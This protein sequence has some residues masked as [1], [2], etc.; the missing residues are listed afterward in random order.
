M[1]HIIELLECEHQCILRNSHGDCTHDCEN[2]DLVRDDY[3][4]H[5]MYM[6]AITILKAQEP[7]APKCG[8]NVGVGWWYACGACNGEIVRSDD[9]C[10][11]CG[12][13]VK[14]DDR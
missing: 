13:K 4:L 5:E 2:C 7:I 12:R 11:H 9:Y 14:W 3:E 10:P 1:G 8:H 6:D